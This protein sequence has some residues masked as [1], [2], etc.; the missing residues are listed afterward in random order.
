MNSCPPAAS[1]I[2]ITTKGDVARFLTRFGNVLR[3]CFTS[4]QDSQFKDNK[5]DKSRIIFWFTR[6]GWPNRLWTR[7]RVRDSACNRGRRYL[8][9]SKLYDSCPSPIIYPV[10]RSC[11]T[12]ESLSKVIKQFKKCVRLLIDTRLKGQWRI[13]R[14]ES[15]A[16]EWS[17]CARPTA[18][19]IALDPLAKVT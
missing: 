14:T 15:K 19:T 4:W 5:E 7:R 17:G 1:H 9:M 8:E 18:L 6:L 3:E 12:T 10:R 2:P 16:K 11:I 13:Y